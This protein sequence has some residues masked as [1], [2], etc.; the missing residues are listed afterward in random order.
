MKNME[1]ITDITADTF[2][3]QVVE[4]SGSMLVL[5]DFW[6]DWCGPCQMQMPM[7]K[8]LVEDYNGKFALAK[9]NTDEQKELARKF[10]IRSLPTMHL[11]KNGEIVE[12]ILAAQTESDMRTLL[13]RHI[14][15]ESDA[16][17]LKAMEAYAQ[18]D[19]EQAFTLLHE[20]REAEPDNHQVTL[21]LIELS[22]KE[23]L[24]E[25]AE[26]YLAEL[27]HDVRNEKEAVRLCSLLDFT[28][29]SMQAA[30]LQEL[31]T[32]VRENPEDLESRYQLAS[33]YVLDNRLEDA[34]NA[35]MYILE[36]DRAFRDDA[37]RTGLL[38]VFDLLGNEG[39][40]VSSYRR[41]L[42]NAMH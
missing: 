14:E 16:I 30:P 21:D 25:Q 2:N 29:T 24:P 15:R 41:R 7:L 9:V 42:F 22:I 3:T 31:E 1:N 33:R 35:F 23:G 39:E 38:A 37:G 28:R 18:G 11:Y 32:T 19:S 27:P 20:T 36:Q 10:K 4:R 40:L 12:E 5:V 26:T 17:R 34:M 8:K 13:E 6:A